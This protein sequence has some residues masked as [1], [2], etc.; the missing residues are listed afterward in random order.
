VKNVIIQLYRGIDA[1]RG[2]LSLLQGEMIFTT[3]RKQAFIYDG[4]GQVLVGRADVGLFASMPPPGVQGLIYYATDTGGA[5]IDDGSAWQPLGAGSASTNYVYLDFYEGN[6]PP[7]IADVDSY[8]F[9][10]AAGFPV[11]EDR[12]VII[13][14]AENIDGLLSGFDINLVYAMSTADVGK[15]VR[16]VLD[17]VV[18]KANEVYNAG[19]SYSDTQDVTIGTGLNELGM[20]QPFS[21]P[22]GNIT[23][24]TVEVEMRLTREGTHVN[25]THSGDFG[26]KHL[27][28]VPV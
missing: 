26:L 13:K 11:G 18:H 22:S 5:Y 12:D 10:D 24:D 23:A 16:L 17:Y 20:I 7:Y 9:Q 4:T 21:I 15:D 14:L 1:N 8:G 2:T 28:V 3:D 19:T 25:D 6:N 27:I